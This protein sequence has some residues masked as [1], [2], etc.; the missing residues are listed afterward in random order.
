MRPLYFR[1][2]FSTDCPAFLID[3]PIAPYDKIAALKV[4]LLEFETD[5]VSI[6]ARRP[7]IQ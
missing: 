5:L 2:C 7:T 1:P 4:R 6:A 3:N